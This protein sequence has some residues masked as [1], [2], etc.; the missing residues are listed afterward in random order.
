M[1]QETLALASAYPK[2]STGVDFDFGGG[3]MFTAQV[4]VGVSFTGTAHEDGAG[5]GVTVPHPYFFNASDTDGVPTSDKLLRTEGATHVQVMLVPMHSANL[6][7]RVF[8]GPSYFRYKADMVQDVE[9]SQ[10]AFPFSR[11]NAV[12]ITGYNAE[13]AEGTGWGFHGG[14]DVSWF[15]SRIVGLGGFARYSRGS[16]SLDREPLSEAQQDIRVGGLQSGGGVRL[17]F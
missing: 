17:R 5:L 8:G 12:V 2:P 16:V 6:R 1:F 3:Y 15:F 4:G 13:K 10:L 9:Y 14:A 11:A 7:L